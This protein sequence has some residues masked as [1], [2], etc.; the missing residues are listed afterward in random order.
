MHWVSPDRA[1]SALPSERRFGE[2]FAGILRDFGRGYSTLEKMFKK[3]DEIARN[4][5]KKCLNRHYL[6]ESMLSD[7]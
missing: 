4:F 1:A 7:R 3:V 2:F 6:D 5:E